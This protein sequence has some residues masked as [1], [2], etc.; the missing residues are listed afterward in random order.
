MPSNYQ[1]ITLDESVIGD[2]FGAFTK[3]VEFKRKYKS[4]LAKI[5][6]DRL[7]HSSSIARATKNLTMSFP[8]ICS[9]AVSGNTAAIINKAI[10]LKN[11]T[12]IQMLA[13]AAHFTGYN[14]IDVISQI[15]TNMGVKYSVDDYIDSILAFKDTMFESGIPLSGMYSILAEQMRDEFLESL[16]HTYPASSINEVSINNYYVVDSYGSPQ[17][18][19]EAP[20]TYRDLLRL[21]QDSIAKLKYIDDKTNADAARDDARKKE[22]TRKAERKEDKQERQADREYKHAQ[23]QF[24]NDVEALKY[25][26]GRDDEAYRRARDA[27][28]DAYNRRRDA[29]RDVNDRYQQKHY[30]IQQNLSA[31]DVKKANELIPTLIVLRYQVTDPKANPSDANLYISDEFVAGVKSRLVPCASN[32]IIDRIVNFHNSKPDMKGLI[33]STTGE[34]KFAKDFLASVQMAKIQ[35]KKDSKLSK[36]NQVWRSLQARSNRSKLNR[37]ARMQNGSAAIATLVITQQEVDMI[38]DEYNIDM[39]NPA[40]C[41]EFMDHYNL[42]AVCIVDEQLEVA[43]FIYDGDAYFEDL[44]FSALQRENDKSYKQVIDLLNKSR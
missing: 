3:A 24:R 19:L 28:N 37:L 2:L 17:V 7:T 39:N 13:A 11:V 31:T 44:S 32:D 34:T 33:K 21:S 41:V 6:A 23:D 12:M 1:Y 30:N 36:T 22:E 40:T 27:S 16:A 5:K 35:A 43:H 18:M 9:D 4:N 42:M 20:M 10:E 29:Q 26:A 8:T 38:K 15:H 14:G 25:N